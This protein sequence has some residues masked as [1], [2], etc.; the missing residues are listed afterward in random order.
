MSE[1]E[2]AMLQD[3]LID[4]GFFSPGRHAPAWPPGEPWSRRGGRGDLETVSF[5]KKS[6]APSPVVAS[7]LGTEEN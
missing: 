2:E 4:R 5:P 3:S 1:G 6:R 7:V